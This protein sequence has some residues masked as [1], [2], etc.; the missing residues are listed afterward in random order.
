MPSY[1]P[2]TRF[3]IDVDGRP[4]QLFSVRQRSNHDLVVMHQRGHSYEAAGGDDPFVSDK[5]SIHVSNRS[6]GTTIKHLMELASGKRVSNAAFVAF[7]KDSLLWP[8]HVMRAPRLAKGDYTANARDRDHLVS[9]GKY[10]PDLQSLYYCTVTV[11]R[12]V[13]LPAPPPWLSLAAADF[14]RFSL[15]LYYAFAATPSAPTSDTLTP[16][17][18]APRVNDVSAGPMKLDVRSMSVDLLFR[19]IAEAFGILAERAWQRVEAHLRDEEDR[20]LINKFGRLFSPT[21]AQNFEDLKD[22]LTSGVTMI[23]PPTDGGATIVID[24]KL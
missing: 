5:T 12:G 16:I 24:R 3:L 2:K 22:K 18:S 6:H 14:S 19:H 21:A 13:Q 17:S 8:L 23:L 7:S 10:R 1:K 20:Q 4:R 11:S 9:L 15:G